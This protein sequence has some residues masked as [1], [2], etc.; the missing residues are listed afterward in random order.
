M[1]S[2]IESQYTAEYIA[3]IFWNQNIAKVSNITLIP[4]LKDSEIYSVAYIAVNQWCESEAA[5]NFIQ[6][7]KN[8]D[9]EARI[10][11]HEDNWWTVELN[12]HNNGN[13]E[14]G[15]YTEWF[16]SNYFT[17]KYVPSTC[18]DTCDDDETVAYTESEDFSNQRPIQGLYDEHYTPEEAEAH[19]QKLKQDL[20]KAYRLRVQDE[21]L[22]ELEYEISHFESELSIHRSVEN[23]Q[24]VTLRDHQKFRWAAIH[25]E[26]NC[27]RR[28]VSWN[29][30]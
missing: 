30:I 29:D 21:C 24:N 7:L 13:L 16:S 26:D 12:T 17:K 25:P 2:N 27:R 19:L 18:D 10:V 23:S 8:P 4:Y 3:N 15:A 22:E 5:Y 11:H 20:V 9:K 6:R 1:I 14:V 28:E